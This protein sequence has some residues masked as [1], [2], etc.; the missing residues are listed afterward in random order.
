MSV[1]DVPKLTT[2]QLNHL[3]ASFDRIAPL[4]LQPFKAMANDPTRKEIDDAISSAFGVKGLN[5]L[6]QMLGFDAIVTGETMVAARAIT[7]DDNEFVQLTLDH[8]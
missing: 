8:L 1:L 7:V 6:R 2:I 3:S 5:R 4:G